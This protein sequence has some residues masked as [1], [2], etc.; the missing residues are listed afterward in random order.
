M[1]IFCKIIAKE[2]PSSIIYED[3][4]IIAFL[5]ISQA[6]R[7]HTL[8]VTKEHFANIYSVD[9][10]TLTHLIKVVQKLSVKLK[11][12]LDANGINILNNN[13]L[14]AG[15]TI[16]HLHFHIIPRYD[17]NDGFSCHFTSN[18]VDL[19]EIAKIINQ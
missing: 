4:K 12:K 3:E 13:E 19:K 10:E 18:E 7:G 8:V 17:E 16:E 6:T 14:S 5:D 11:T 2:I 15:Q 1:C 9:E